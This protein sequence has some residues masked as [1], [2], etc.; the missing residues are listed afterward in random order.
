MSKNIKKIIVFISCPNDVSKEKEVVKKVCNE[1]SSIYKKR[2]VEIQAIEWNE[3]FNHLI[4]VE[5]PQEQIN[6]EIENSKYDIYI[7]ILWSRFGDIQ[8][9]NKLSPTEEE[10]ENALEKK[11]QCRNLNI[12]FYFKTDT[13]KSISKNYK[14]QKKQI[15]NFKEKI[16]NLGLYKEFKSSEF[17]SILFKDIGEIVDDIL[18]PAIEKKAYK[19]NPDYI[20][21]KVCLSKD[22]NEKTI[23]YELEKQ[24]DFIDIISRQDKIVLISDAGMGKTTELSRVEYLLSKKESTFIPYF[25]SLNTYTNQSICMLLK[26][27]WNEIFKKIPVVILDGLDEIESKNRMDAIRNIEEFSV[28]YPSVKVI[29]SC[30]NNFY[31]SESENYSGTLKGFSTYIL[32][33]LEQKE[34]DKYSNKKLGIQAAFF[35][36]I[37]IEKGLADI[38]KIPFCLIHLVDFFREKNNLPQNK[39]EIFEK[40]INLRIE[41]DIEIYRTTV[42]L[43][44]QKN[45][46]IFAF[47]IIALTME[48][49]GRNYIYDEE[50]EKI[51]KVNDIKEILG[52]CLL[53]KKK[54]GNNTI[55]N[56]EHNNFQEYLAAR[57]LSRQ[58]LEIVKKFIFFSPDYKVVI[59]SWLNT[60]SF[61]VS[62]FE[63]RDLLNWIINN[64]YE[65][66]V[67]FEKDKIGEEK[68][69]KIFKMIFNKYKESK[70]WINQDKF[71]YYE[72]ADFG[73]SLEVI[74]F[75]LE[76]GKKNSHY[77]NKFNAIELLRYMK[78]PIPKNKQNTIMEFLTNIALSCENKTIQSHA[79]LALADWKLNS[80]G[81]IEKIL[82]KL[83]NSPNDVIRYALY[84]LIN[85]SEH[86]DEYID[87]CLEGFQY[88]SKMEIVLSPGVR[89]ETR[90]LDEEFELKNCLTKANSFGAIKKI[91][92]Y[93]TI[94]PEQ[95]K[96]PI[97]EKIIKDIANNAANIYSEYQ[98][99]FNFFIDLFISFIK[100]YMDKQAKEIIY[101]FD[102]TNTRFQAFKEVYYNKLVNKEDLKILAILANKKCLEFLIS[103]YLEG[104]IKDENIK[105]FQNVLN[106]EQFNLFEI[107][108]K[109]I[110]N[111]TSDKFLIVLPKSHEKERKERIQKDFDL[112]FDKEL[113]LGEIEKVFHEENSSSFSRKEL[114]HLMARYPKNYNM[115][116][117]V[118][119][120]LIKFAKEKN[121]TLKEVQAYLNKNWENISISKVYK[122]LKSYNDLK[123]SLQQKDFIKNWCNS[124][125]KYIN[126]KNALKV[127]NDGKTLSASWKAIFLSY[128]MV[129]F[130]ICYEK[131]IMLDMIS[132]DLP[133][134]N[135]IS[136]IDYLEKC[137]SLPDIKQRIFENLEEGKDNKFVLKNYIN[138]CK[139]KNIKEII[140]YVEEIIVSF[141]KE[142]DEILRKSALD[143]INEL[144]TT[145]ELEKLLLEVKDKFKWKIVE[146]L[147]KKKSSKLKDFLLQILNSS[148]VE[149][150]INATKYLVK[151][152]DLEGLEYYVNWLLTKKSYKIESLIE[153]SPLI[154]LEDIKAIPL[155]INL[156][157]KSYDPEF[158]QDDF[159]RLDSD[160]LDALTNIALKSEKN[161]I[162]VKSTIENFIAQNSNIFKNV[163]FLNLFL[164]NL[165]RKFYRAKS[166]NISI[167][168]AIKKLEIIK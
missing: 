60:L 144:S 70:T 159:Y 83:R 148:Y 114:L 79:L 26:E 74:N 134:M 36:E 157:E 120:T 125:L 158:I 154:F 64:C 140:P 87:I 82:Q 108:N 52:F 96:N 133:W 165:E 110:N 17:E 75:L 31:I 138:F 49:L 39:T 53:E 28:N 117:M 50:L 15:M 35:K 59:P 44:K 118:L 145:E 46:I 115:S 51:P 57:I 152:N 43:M 139:Q 71:Y 77:T 47:E 143:A 121:I 167:E 25:I 137:L 67:K 10:F 119:H 62:I 94:Q 8:I 56:F 123:I 23:F 131:N 4:T 22:Y 32:L 18:H 149:D 92:K 69:I 111:K 66:V 150:K 136:G 88:C 98:D 128:F 27:G 101:F 153:K 33:N 162:N 20:N 45:C 161:Y 21:R 41:K 122:Y 93:F 7:G 102:K 85:S 29:I 80:K 55:W 40:I 9:D 84:Y 129:R 164:E 105:M 86:L 14:E 95:L 100:K 141:N 112:L 38:T 91:V 19:K 135:S 106:W 146:I 132:F 11:K 156:L 97:F 72:L 5:R 116:D 76:E 30:R 168:N 160:V 42:D 142:S 109:E 163:N 37:V 99:V 166:E 3:D 104:K 107:F 2:N 16:K 68:R 127:E 155:L 113:F 151:L 58:S 73:K 147:F 81:I 34:I 13:C 103:E 48:T 61:L 130:N 24:N 89:K 126:F 6:R 12:K 54:Q 78:M 65:V 1:I 124:N 63:T 90:I